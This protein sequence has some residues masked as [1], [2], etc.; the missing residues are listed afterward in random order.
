MPTLSL[1]QLWRTVAWFVALSVF[2]AP[3]QPPGYQPLLRT[4]LAQVEPALDE[5]F[6]ILAQLESRPGWTHFPHA[7]LAAAVLPDRHPLALRIGDLLAREHESGAFTNRLDWHRDTYMWLEAYRLLAPRLD[8]PRRARWQKCLR[9]QIET[10]AADTARDESAPRLTGLFL[11]TSPNHYALWA[12]TVFLGGKVFDVPAWSALGRR[13]LSRFVLEQHP[14]GFWGE[15]STAAPT[16]GY[17][18]LTLSAVGVYW[19]H[20]QDPAAFEAL[21]RSTNLHANFTYS[22]GHP[23]ELLND[24]NRH[25]FVS[26]W[27]HFA[28]S[29]FPH[30]RALAAR[31]IPAELTLETLGRLAQNQLY[32]HPGPTGPAPNRSLQIPISLQQSGDWTVILSGLTGRAPAASPW[33]LD[34]QSHVS[35]YHD[36]LGLIVNGAPSKRQPELATFAESIALDGYASADQVSLAYEGFTARIKATL[37]PDVGLTFALRPHGPN[38]PAGVRVALQLQLYAG[39]TLETASGRSVVLG[40]ELV[41]IDDCGPWIRH[42]GWTIHLPP[43]ASLRWPQFGYNPYRGKPDDALSYAVGL[44]AWRQSLSDA[45]V[46]ISVP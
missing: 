13:I 31:S 1:V 11:G 37:R 7:I 34:R 39:E 46:L 9:A 21:R 23:A 25:W 42:H 26:P 17:N 20:S 22:D 29:H 32:W 43:G 27:A 35:V 3:N 40:P 6:L 19:E 12:S 38:P 2:A 8:P 30:G 45:Q 33:F 4:G 16:L 36:R 10:L 14:D 5:T 28:F 41:S 18:A 24:R 15:Q 44:V